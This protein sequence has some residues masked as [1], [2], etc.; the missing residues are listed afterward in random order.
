MEQFNLVNL[1]QALLEGGKLIFQSQKFQPSIISCVKP[2]DLET[3]SQF[4][5]EK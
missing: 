3:E 4:E 5:R 1:K 2:G